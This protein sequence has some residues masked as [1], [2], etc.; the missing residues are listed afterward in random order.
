MY[1]C[2]VPASLDRGYISDWDRY[3]LWSLK[4]GGLQHRLYCWAIENQLVS[5]MD[6]MELQFYAI[7]VAR[8]SPTIP[9]RF[10][11]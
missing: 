10:L 1:Q 9:G 5:L 11:E 4:C 6:R 3:R 8:P 2:I 7:S